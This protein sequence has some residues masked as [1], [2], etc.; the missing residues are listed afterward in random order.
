MIKQSSDAAE[1]RGSWSIYLFI[2]LRAV[3]EKDAF[4]HVAVQNLLYGRHVT[5]YDILH[6]GTTTKTQCIRGTAASLQ[7]QACELTLISGSQ[8][9][10]NC[11]CKMWNRKQAENIWALFQSSIDLIILTQCNI[12]NQCSQ[13]SPCVTKQHLRANACAHVVYEPLLERE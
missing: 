13:I 4:L 5:F 9:K 2:F 3:S 10:K 6:L 12:F 7:A 8:K 1:L 11:L